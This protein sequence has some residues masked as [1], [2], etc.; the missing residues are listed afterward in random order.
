A[1]IVSVRQCFPDPDWMI[2]DSL[3]RYRERL[4]YLVSPSDHIDL[5]ERISRADRAKWDWPILR[6]E[7][8]K[9]SVDLISSVQSA[10]FV[11]NLNY[12]PRPVFQSYSTY[13]TELLEAN[14]D[15]LAQAAGP[16]FLVIRLEPID[17]RIAMLEDALAWQEVLY[18]YRPVTVEK[19]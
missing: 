6:R 2:A 7:I 1:G 10:L 3:T 14:A 4:H 17:Q 5:L 16:D 19:D 11:N 18:R 9:R 12:R 15:A 13:T 8:G